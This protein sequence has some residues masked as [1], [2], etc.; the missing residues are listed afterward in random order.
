MNLDLTNEKIML[1]LVNII[2]GAVLIFSYYKYINFGG[3]DIKT[4]WG[5][6]Y[7]VKKLYLASIILAGLAY[8]LLLFF[9]IFKTVN[10]KRNT[11]LLSNLTVIQVLIIVISMLWLPLTLVYL[12]EG[13]K[14]FAM[15]AVL[16]V[17]FMVGIAS[18]KQIRLIQN[19]V[20]ENTK[21][22]KMTQQAA[23]VG[24]GV[25][26]IHTFFFDFIG[27]SCGFFA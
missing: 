23:V 13:K 22:A 18:F 10:T 27:W 6:A 17:L 15:L 9:A 20:S 24:A 12:K 14:P 4:L 5:K 1:I 11:A 16:I 7:S 8:A 3:V 21:C 25:F 2:F 26:F 19:L